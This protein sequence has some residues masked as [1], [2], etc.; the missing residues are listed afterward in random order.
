[1]GRPELDAQRVTR[2]NVQLSGMHTF[3]E[4]DIWGMD[5]AFE[6]GGIEAVKESI[7]EDW[8]SFL[9][10]FIPKGGKLTDLFIITPINPES[11]ERPVATP[12]D[13]HPPVGEG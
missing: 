3:T 6:H 1:M 8:T 2:F 12:S 11:Y 13:T 4:D 9:E 10:E 5:E 7:M